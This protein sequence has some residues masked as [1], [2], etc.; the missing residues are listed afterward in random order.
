MYCE[1]TNA[2]PD[3]PWLEKFVESFG[4]FP[5]GAV[6]T[7]NVDQEAQAKNPKSD[8]TFY[9]SDEAFHNRVLEMVMLH[10]SKGEDDKAHRLART[11]KISPVRPRLRERS[12]DL[13]GRGICKRCHS[14][15][16]QSAWLKDLAASEA[17]AL[18]QNPPPSL[19]PCR[20]VPTAEEGVN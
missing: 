19:P 3:E 11:P 14:T 1:I 5:P 6:I 17:R 4:S 18:R 15:T 8:R 20:L 12:P 2:G 9:I 16:R 10:K 7:T 13:D